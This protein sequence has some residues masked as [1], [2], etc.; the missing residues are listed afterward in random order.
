MSP[1]LAFLSET[2][3]R[4]GEQKLL[5]EKTFVQLTD[6]E[7]NR[8]PAPGSNAVAQIIQHLSGNMKSRWTRFL[9][10]DGEKPDRN[11][12]AEFETSYHSRAALLQLWADGWDIYLGALRQLTEE[13][14]GKTVFIRSQP[15]L[16]TAAIVR[17]TAHYSYHVGQ[18]VYVGKL[19]KGEAF[20]SLSIPLGASQQYNQQLGH[21]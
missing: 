21:R 2:I 3:L 14:L 9:T 11:R 20:R 13:D 19:L 4:M 6:D 12:D 18:I 17:Q 5:A 7:L 1:A 16:V 8:S 10:D 15:L